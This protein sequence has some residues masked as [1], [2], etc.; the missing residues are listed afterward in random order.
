MSYNISVSSTESSVLSL[1]QLLALM[2]ASVHL[3]WETAPADPRKLHR[4]D[5]HVQWGFLM[6]GYYLPGGPENLA[7]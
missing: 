6:V 1:W 7:F 4:D 3:V 5:V 2:G